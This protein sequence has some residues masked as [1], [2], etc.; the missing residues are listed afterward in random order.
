ML[1]LTFMSFYFSSSDLL[2]KNNG[3]AK[4]MVRP[5]YLILDIGN[6]GIVIPIMVQRH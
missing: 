5:I 3:T 1:L 4:C 2:Y 6:C